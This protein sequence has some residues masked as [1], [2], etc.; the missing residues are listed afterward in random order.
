MA[1]PPQ[2][3]LAATGL[4]SLTLIDKMK[5]MLTKQVLAACD[6]LVLAKKTCD[7]GAI[8]RFFVGQCGAD[9]ISSS[10][11]TAGLMSSITSYYEKLMEEDEV[12]IEKMGMAMVMFFA[13]IDPEKKS[14]GI[15]QWVPSHFLAAG[16]RYLIQGDVETAR[17]YA[18]F[19]CF[20]EQIGSV[21]K[22]KNQ[23]ISQR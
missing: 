7:F 5:E 22:Q 21:I 1:T 10:S 3:K 12:G 6:D 17:A 14:T 11:N 16:A 9:L 2:P 15:S 4:S 18:Y 13:H 8:D 19:N 23:S 20:F